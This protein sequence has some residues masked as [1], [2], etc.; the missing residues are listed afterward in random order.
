MRTTLKQQ[1][2]SL[3]TE[4]FGIWSNYLNQKPYT[5]GTL[6]EQSVNVM[7]RILE[8][9]TRGDSCIDADLE[10]IDYL[11][12]LVLEEKQVSPQQVA[13]FVYDQNYLYLYRY[14]ALERALVEQIVRLKQQN[15]PS[16]PF[17]VSEE[18]FSDHHQKQALD[19][20]VKNSLSIITGGP[21][22]GKTYTLAR[23]IAVLNRAEPNLRIAMAA[24][25]GKAAQRMKE[26]LQN[27][28]SDPKLE[29][30]LN[31]D[32]KEITP[33]TI[34]RLLGLGH[35]YT[36]KFSAKQ[37]LPYDLI[38]VDEASM[39]DLNLAT[40]LFCAIPD[41]AR[42]ILLGDAQ[43]LASV[44]VGN[45]LADLQSMNVLSAN[46]M[47]LVKSR[48]FK[49]GALIGEMA[50]FIQ[51]EHDLTHVLTDFEQ[52]IV[53]ASQLQDVLLSSEMSDVLQ[54]EYLPEDIS[55][56]IDLTHY[57]DQLFLGFQNYTQ[58]IQQFEES[59]FSHDLV[60]NVVY[61]FDQY[62]ILTAIRY[63]YFGLITL[64]GQ[65]E[66]RFLNKTRQIKQ[67]DW[68]IGR[69]VMMSYNDY[70]LGLSNGDIGIC[71]KRGLSDLIP[72]E[73]YFPSLEKWVLANRL[74][75][76]IETAFVLTIHKSQGSEFKHTAV[77]LDKMATNLLSKELIYTAITR[78]KSVVSLLVD[79]TAFEQALT[80]KTVR[81]SGLLTKITKLL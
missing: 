13:P 41:Q 2:E 77:V 80:I 45:I 64:N 54:L 79:K 11:G 21:G 42:L 12:N 29:P 35:T 56:F 36:P 25:T 74:P 75:N 76:N 31:K 10:A 73:V 48:R 71:F 7:Q 1:P 55:S 51:K 69:P 66:Q 30:Y 62:R 61:A 60:L 52:N 32:L 40:M 33:I 57:Y 59:E 16:I 18:L 19:T 6:D 63:S 14:W 72:F 20:V 39:L 46:R 53:S 22:T 68:Y 44:E 43:Q 81:K 15:I 38:V 78:A 3:S 58:V 65:I 49:E 4:W 24:P 67:G 26:A 34:H 70:Q 47:N 37:P 5:A 28:F 17:M 23:I 50:K 9:T 27:S 8:A